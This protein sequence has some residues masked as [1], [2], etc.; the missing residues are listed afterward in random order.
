MFDFRGI[1]Q[2]FSSKKERRGLRVKGTGVVGKHP[3]PPWGVSVSG[4]V[5]HYGARNVA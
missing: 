4:Y 2:V 3:F 5:P 1:L